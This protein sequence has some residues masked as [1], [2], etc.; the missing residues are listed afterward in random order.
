MHGVELKA[1]IEKDGGVAVNRRPIGE[2]AKDRDQQQ[3]IARNEPVPR[4]Y[5]YQH[6]TSQHGHGRHYGDHE[7]FANR[8]KTEKGIC[9]GGGNGGVV[10][11]EYHNIR[12]QQYQSNV[13]ISHLVYRFERL[14]VE[15]LGGFPRLPHR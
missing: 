10:I 7:P 12:H 6:L 9:E 13:Y 5:I 15:V 2:Y 1:K 8:R 3:Q 4:N 11:T 14:H